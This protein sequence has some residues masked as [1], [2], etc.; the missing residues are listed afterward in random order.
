[1]SLS[2]ITAIF[3]KLVV[4]VKAQMLA[5]TPNKDVLAVPSMLQLFCKHLTF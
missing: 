1:M 2:K 5:F 3:V 4:F